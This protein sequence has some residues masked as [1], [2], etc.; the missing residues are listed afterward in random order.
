MRADQQL[1]DVAAE[2][3]AEEARRDVAVGVLD[4][5]HHHQAGHDEVHVAEAAHVADAAADQAAEDQE[6]QRHG[7]RR[8]HQGLAP[9]AQ[10]AHDLAADD[11]V[12][13][14]QVG[15]GG[16]D[17]GSAGHQA[18]SLPGQ[19]HEQ[20]FEAV[21]ALR[22]ERTRMPASLSAAKMRVE[23]HRP[24]HL[25]S[26]CGLVAAL[27]RMPAIAG[28][29]A[30]KALESSTKPSTS[31]L[32][33]SVLHRALLDDAAAVDDGEVAAEVLGLFEVVRG[34]DD[35]GAARR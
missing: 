18:A 9:D 31:S 13:R 2:L 10:D 35:R 7:D 15:A 8:R 11:G 22:I 14:G 12:E 20:F 4:D 25:E 28:S 32:A 26:A 5:A 21:G 1:L 17:R 29:A 27:D 33:S 24:R 3:R 34:Q 23:V 30:G 16:A 19:A 6:V